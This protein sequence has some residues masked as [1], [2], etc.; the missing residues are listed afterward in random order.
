LVI[1]VCLRYWFPILD[2]ETLVHSPK[3]EPIQK[4]E[5][6]EIVDEQ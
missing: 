4:K 3:P 2:E 6:K 1:K 5:K